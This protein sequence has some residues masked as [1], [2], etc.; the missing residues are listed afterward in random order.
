LKP[1]FVKTGIYLL[2]SILILFMLVTLLQY[3][4][5]DDH[6]GFLQYKQ[7]WLGDPV[8][9][10]AFYIHVFTCFFCLFA[11][12]TQF[13]KEVMRRQKK[14]HR[15]LGKIYVFNILF[16]NVPVGM[17]LAVNANG[18]LLSKIAFSLLGILWCYF[19]SM[20]WIYARRKQFVRHRHFMIRSYALTLSALT[21]R[22][23]K[24]VL[25]NLTTLDTYTIYQ[26]DAWLGF[27]LNLLVAEWIIRREI[28]QRSR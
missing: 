11:G 20:A 15:L 23:W 16:I 19:T 1:L 6:T 22:L 7:D 24:P 18:G 2:L 9:K 21:L 10:S 25:M 28:N 17:I 27:G 13:S 4:R 8:W 3:T 26:I 5:L 14:T 12:L